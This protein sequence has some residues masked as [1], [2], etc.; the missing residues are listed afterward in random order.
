MSP[1]MPGRVIA[2]RPG[3]VGSSQLCLGMCE[4]RSQSAGKITCVV[5]SP[6]Q[7][8]EVLAEKPDQ[9]AL[10]ADERHQCQAG[11]TFRFNV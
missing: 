4:V 1:D 6:A 5:N 10:T 9:M 2:G 11:P 8:T 3:F 7:L